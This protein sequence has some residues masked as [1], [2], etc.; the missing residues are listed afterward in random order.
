MNIINQ[1]AIIF[2]FLALGELTVRLTAIPIPASI[3]GMILLTG[4]LKLGVVKPRQIEQLSDFLIHNLGLFFIPA[5]VG[6]MNCLGIIADQWVPIV[7]ATI[8]STIIII[9]VTGWVH[10]LVRK[11]LSRKNFRHT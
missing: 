5:G 1:S 4:A 6:V 3:I 2:A 7:G 10:R 11:Q 8:G 9:A